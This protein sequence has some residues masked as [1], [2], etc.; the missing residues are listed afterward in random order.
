MTT[1]MAGTL[2]G[3]VTGTVT[4]TVSGPVSGAGTGDLAAADAEACASR[5]YEVQL[6]ATRL[7]ACAD[8]AEAVL[9]QLTR[10]ELQGWQSPAG[11]A[12]RTAL[13]LHAASLRRS[14]DALQ[15]AAAA[16]LRHARNVALS[17]ERT[18]F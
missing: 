14:R 11:R 16:A 15:D 17:A 9:F 10:L 2:I 13:S 8:Q 18:G 3:K 4:G 5:S 12:Y 6:L 1:G 7:T